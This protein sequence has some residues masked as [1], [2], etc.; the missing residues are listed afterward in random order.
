MELV[1]GMV[2]GEGAAMMQWKAFRVIEADDGC[3]GLAGV[4]RL[5]L[6]VAPRMTLSLGI[7]VEAACVGHGGGGVSR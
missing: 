7:P 1:I 4:W 5:L 6:R 2:V 3:R